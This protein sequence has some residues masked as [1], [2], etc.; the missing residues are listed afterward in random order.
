MNIRYPI[1][2]GVYRILTYNFKCRFFFLFFLSPGLSGVSS[3]GE[4]GAEN[5]PPKPASNG[6]SALNGVRVGS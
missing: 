6:L 2:E 5:R 4:D 3:A 1:Y